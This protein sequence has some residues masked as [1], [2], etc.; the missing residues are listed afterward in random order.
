[1]KTPIPTLPHNP[2]PTIKHDP[3][4]RLSLAVGEL[5]KLINRAN[6]L[7]SLSEQPSSMT[8]QDT[9]LPLQEPSHSPPLL[10]RSQPY[11]RSGEKLLKKGKS[12]WQVLRKNKILL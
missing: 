5:D 3:I 11:K 2:S 6:Q 4:K 10:L 9:L 12:H 7:A 8:R 1:M